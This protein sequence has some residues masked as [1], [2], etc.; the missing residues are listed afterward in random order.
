MW[1]GLKKIR[2]TRGKQMEEAQAGCDCDVAIGTLTKRAMHHIQEPWQPERD[3]DSN[4]QSHDMQRQSGITAGLSDK[5]L[6]G[7]AM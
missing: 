5:S 1:V 6:S 4:G 3:E 7:I 2:R